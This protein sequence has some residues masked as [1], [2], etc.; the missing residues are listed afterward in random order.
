M[1]TS[2]FNP[3]A[4]ELLSKRLRTVTIFIAII[5][6]LLLLRLWFLQIVNGPFYR[7][8]SENNRIHLQRI[9]PFRGLIMDRDGELLVDNRPSY[10]LYLIPEEL[11]E[12]ENLFNRLD[13]LI[14][15][16]PDKV[17]AILSRHPA[18]HP[19]R[20][21][22]IRKG[23]SREDL[24]V[25]EANLFNLPG[26]MIQVTHQR[27]YIYGKLASH[28]I[29]YLGEINK[30]QL[31]SGRYYNNI[32]GDLIGKYG[33]E[34]IWQ[35]SLNG[36]RGG[37]QVEVDAAGRRLSIIAKKP[38]EPGYNIRL[39]IDRELQMMAEDALQGKKGAI[40]A[41]DPNSGRVLAMASNPA[42]DPNR[43]IRGM[44]REEW[45]SLETDTDYPFRNRAITGEYPPGSVFKI[46][47]ALAALEEG[48]VDPDD[49][50]SCSGV[51]TLGNH[52]FRCWRREG[53]GAVNLHRALKESCDIYFYRA[54]IRLGIDRIAYYSKLFGLGSR[55]SI[56][57]SHERG[58][59]IPTT[60]W[61]LKRFGVPWQA[62]E[63]VSASIG[64]SFVLVTPLQM[65]SMMSVV[66]N[67]GK[68]YRPK[69]VEWAGN[70]NEEIFRFKPE[71]EGRINFHK[72]NLEVVKNALL[73]SVKEPRGTATRAD[74]KGVNIAGK[75]GTAQ[76]V[77]LDFLKNRYPD[78]DHPSHFED[79][80][81]FVAVAPVENPE[82]VFS[83]LIEN[84]GGGGSVAAPIA[85]KLI[86]K[87]LDMNDSQG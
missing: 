63:T 16:N 17:K 35:N 9:P 30:Q 7:T 34:S 19:F 11:K 21:V 10:D 62:G 79:H 54:G 65:A 51:Y 61:K 76:V 32:Q 28:I 38:P 26:V 50:I 75:T 72:E 49:E 37:M 53:H 23:I 44:S 2:G 86:Q 77:S 6:L 87:Y 58:G 3:I 18:S 15:V 73:A 4:V 39:T 82:I 33:V 14:S 29:G 52:Q 68:I 66:F 83:I 12:R 8:R 40:V 22:L 69:I 70:D 25:I 60:E 45:N 85:K 46:V 43:F 31:A 1:R 20:P 24:A 56:E 59:L 5:I 41:L 64:Q 80:A 36:V 74:I 57:L 55:T 81:W 42:V 27:N 67:G 71:L 47:V 13:Q 48:I 78:G 84:G